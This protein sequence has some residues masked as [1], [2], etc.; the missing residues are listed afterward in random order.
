MSKQKR[1]MQAAAARLL[2]YYGLFVDDAEVIDAQSA[3]NNNTPYGDEV[4]NSLVSQGVPIVK[5]E[6]IAL[7]NILINTSDGANFISDIV[8]KINDMVAS[9]GDLDK[10]KILDLLRIFH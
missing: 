9:S 4:Q 7:N 6:H 10:D 5:S 2:K 3:F 1:K 8:T